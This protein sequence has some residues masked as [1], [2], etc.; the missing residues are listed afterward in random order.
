MD[1]L[2]QGVCKDCGNGTLDNELNPAFDLTEEDDFEM[3]HCNRCGSIHLDILT[4]E[5]L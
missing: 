1:E 4:P 5:T 3:L 2:I